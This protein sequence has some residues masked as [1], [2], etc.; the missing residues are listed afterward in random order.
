VPSIASAIAHMHA[1]RLLGPRHASEAATLNLLN[2]V[3]H[4]LLIQGSVEATGT[5]AAD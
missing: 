2:R 1:K 5:L 4:G 3:L